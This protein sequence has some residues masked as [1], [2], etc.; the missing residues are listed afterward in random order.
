MFQN[1]VRGIFASYVP[2]VW[3]YSDLVAASFESL[4]SVEPTRV[5]MADYI[6]DNVFCNDGY[7]INEDIKQ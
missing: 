1:F 7:I 5:S 3:R 4:P 6:T 2:Y